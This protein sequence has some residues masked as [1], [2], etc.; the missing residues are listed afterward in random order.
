MNLRLTHFLKRAGILVASLLAITVC[1][2]LLLSIDSP[3]PDD[4][5]IRIT[6]TEITTNDNAFTYLNSATNLLFWPTNDY[7]LLYETNW[8]E[9]LVSNIL[10]NNEQMFPLLYKA[11]A[12]QRYQIP[13]LTNT[14]DPFPYLSGLRT[15]ARVMTLR[16]KWLAR[17][18]QAHQSLDQAAEIVRLGYLIENCDGVLI[19][20]LIGSVV[21][22]MGLA[23][24]ESALGSTGLT[25]E[26]L[27]AC[28]RELAAYRQ[29]DVALANTF[30]AE[31]AYVCRCLDM[32]TKGG[33][34]NVTGETRE[35]GWMRRLAMRYAFHPNR[36][37][38][39]Q[40]DAIRLFIADAS[41]PQADRQQKSGTIGIYYE[42]SPWCWLTPNGVGKRLI[43][44]MK[45]AMLKISELQTREATSLAGIR[46]CL[47]L[48]SYEIDHGRIP[49]SLSDLVPDYID[50]VPADPY[51]GKP[52]RYAPEKRILYSI[53]SDLKDSGGS[54]NCPSSTSTSRHT[55][56]QTAD[57]VF[58]I[59]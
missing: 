3:Q 2:V 32:Y 47:S 39:L 45:P 50:S 25:S 41:K 43:E 44:Q 36:A 7:E 21:S 54:T 49:D 6:R 28:C 9:G 26:D 1:A 13:A 18:D 4:S 20:F 59:K 11:L 57:A 10:T 16:T 53:G 24:V 35:I 23:E 8:N 15:I 22:M 34:N 42:I 40:S 30:R 5:D 56:W 55:R 46:L 29:S 19:H 33:P 52:M 51:D 12:C 14:L 58:E 31:Y 38:Q 48:R 27:K 17:H 37:R